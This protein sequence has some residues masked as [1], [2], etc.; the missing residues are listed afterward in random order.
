MP[1]GT[2]GA[3]N[4]RAAGEDKDRL[5]RCVGR[6][7]R[8]GCGGRPHRC[9]KGFG[10]RRGKQEQDEQPRSKATASP[11]EER[12]PQPDQR[13]GRIPQAEQAG[14]ERLP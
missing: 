14:R 5:A 7:D 10:T 6:R 2:I 4:Q 8:D 12:Q 13:H 11:D 1:Q 3:V 9:W